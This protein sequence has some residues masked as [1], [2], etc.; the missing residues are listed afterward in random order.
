MIRDGAGNLYGTTLVGGAPCYLGSPDCGTVFKVDPTGKETV[1]Y[2]FTVTSQAF[3]MAALI[4]DAEGNLYGTAAG[5]GYG[6]PVLVGAVFEVLGAAPV[7]PV[8]IVVPGAGAST[9]TNDTIGVDQW[10]SCDS[11]LSLHNGLADPLGSL[12]SLQYDVKGNTAVVLSPTQILMQSDSISNIGR[13]A[14]QSILQCSNNPSAGVDPSLLVNDVACTTGW[15]GCAFARGLTTT[16]VL[17]TDL[18]SFSG[19]TL[20]QFND[21]S[22][23]LLGA[24]MM[25]GFDPQSWA[26]DFRRDISSLADD[27][28][29]E[30]KKVSSN[31]PGRPIVI[32]AHSEGSIITAAMIAQNPEVYP[33]FLNKV[34]SLGAP[35]LGAIDPYLYAQGWKAFLPFM[36]TTNTALL[37]NNW[38]SVY[39]LLPQWPFFTPLIPPSPSVSQIVNGQRS[40][41]WPA[42]PRPTVLPDVNNPA[43]VW[44]EIRALRPQSFP[45]W[46]AFI[47]YGHSSNRQIVQ[48]VSDL[49][50]NLVFSKP[51]LT[52][53]KSDGDGTVPLYSSQA[54]SMV[55]PDKMIYVQ[56][57]HAQLPK[58]GTVINGILNI[59]NGTSA[60]SVSGLVP[61]SQVPTFDPLNII[62]INACSPVAISVT[63]SSG[64]TINSQV[65]Q[66]QNATYENIAD[67]T[68]IELPWNDVFQV[69]ITGTGNGT[70][71]LVVNGTGG[72]HAPISYIFRDVPVLQG[73]QG[74]VS[75]GGTTVPTLQYNYAGKNVIDTIPANVTPPTIL[76]TGCYFIVQNLRAT[77]AFNVGYSGGVSAFTYNYRSSS[78]TVQFVSTVTSA[79]SIS[80]N[81]ATFSG[82]GTLNGQAGYSFTVNAT[83]GG[84]PG[85]GLDTVTV[86][87]T[88]PKAYSYSANATVV[89]G[90]V[91]VHE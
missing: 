12:A 24:L 89:G 48:T 4:L 73:S 67:A 35:F 60:F 29:T 52:L 5:A 91:I 87:I 68:Q 71:D 88:G 53:Q 3:P 6:V 9:L 44:G 2:A 46:Y 69:Q 58:N 47:G 17:Q 85:S 36:S 1:L 16:S 63:D 8:V 54:G 90:D 7:K 38:T 83:D 28:Y 19:G 21:P 33:A 84:G 56:E 30:V 49:V 76:C 18:V 27:L 22:H 20:L 57:E 70:F 10:L 55:S 66:I 79:I 26:Y 45:N 61:E 42:L 81:T 86:K 50:N 51:C 11:I 43:S 37:G 72:D 39:Q 80:G 31:Y 13:P 64:E 41:H 32:V 62:T 78:Q 15:L 23:S 77:F 82:Q 40:V 74:S 25:N 59:L 14:T 65:S 34:V 75:V